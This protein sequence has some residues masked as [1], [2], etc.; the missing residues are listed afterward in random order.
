MA[1]R[2]IVFVGRQ[3]EQKADKEVQRYSNNEVDDI[4]YFELR[5]CCIKLKRSSDAFSGINHCCQLNEIRTLF[6]SFDTRIKL[7]AVS[8]LP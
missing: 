6:I 8:V 2:S 1:I 4:L 5:S 7:F 3:V